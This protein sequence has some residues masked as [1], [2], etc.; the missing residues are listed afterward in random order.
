MIYSHPFNRCSLLSKYLLYLASEIHIPFSSFSVASL[1][2]LKLLHD[3]KF[4]LHIKAGKIMNSCVSYHS[5]LAIFCTLHSSLLS[6]ADCSES[7][8]T[9]M[10]SPVL[11]P[12]LRNYP[13]C[14]TKKH[15]NYP[16]FSNL[17]LLY[18]SLSYFSRQK[19]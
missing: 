4:P 12:K 10:N 19:K 16:N 2:P 14:L 3:G 8:Q 6:F 5:V 11:T 18:P 1:H 15:L 17:F 7:F 9:Y 13:A